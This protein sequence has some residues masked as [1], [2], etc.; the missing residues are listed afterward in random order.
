MDFLEAREAQKS[1]EVNHD[2]EVYQWEKD[3]VATL[4]SGFTTSC[5]HD[6]NWNV[7]FLSMWFANGCYMVRLQDRENK[8]RCFV[9]ME[10]I[11]KLFQVLDLKM[12][13]GRLPWR[14]EKAKFKEDLSLR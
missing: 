2:S 8:E 9:E 10:T 1:S 14:P 3:N 4:H 12:K 11:D 5:I 6:P 13:T 7:L